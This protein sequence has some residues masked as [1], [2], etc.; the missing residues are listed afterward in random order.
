MALEGLAPIAA[1]A[2]RAPVPRLE[3]GVWGGGMLTESWYLPPQDGSSEEVNCRE[4]VVLLVYFLWVR[5]YGLRSVPLHWAPRF[6]TV[7]REH[8]IFSLEIFAGW[9]LPNTYMDHKIISRKQPWNTSPG[10]PGVPASPPRSTQPP[11]PR[12]GAL[13]CGAGQAAG[14]SH[15]VSLK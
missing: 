3:N 7:E 2:A 8:G 9:E 10:A 15:A 1:C 5:L 12:Q 14:R 6:A 11:R 13:L 4:T